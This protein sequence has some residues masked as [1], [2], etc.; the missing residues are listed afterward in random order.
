MQPDMDTLEVKT[1][2]KDTSLWLVEDAATL[3][4]DQGLEYRVNLYSRAYWQARNTTNNSRS[5]WLLT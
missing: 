1:V 3:L 4:S 2:T 5:D